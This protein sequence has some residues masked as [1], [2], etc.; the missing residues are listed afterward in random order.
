MGKQTGSFGAGQGRFPQALR[1]GFSPDLFIEGD[2]G[3][4]IFPADHAIRTA[5]YLDS[6]IPRMKDRS[7]RIR[8]ETKIICGSGLTAKKVELRWCF[9]PL[10]VE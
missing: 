6:V 3:R 7:N 1:G 2:G 5:L 4:W 10:G 9:S 8:P